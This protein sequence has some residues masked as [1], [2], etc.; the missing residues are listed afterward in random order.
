[1]IVINEDKDKLPKD[2]ERDSLINIEN[3]TKANKHVFYDNET[4]NN[5]RKIGN[6]Y[7]F[8]FSNGNPTIVIGPH[9]ILL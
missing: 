7:L 2:H 9:C 8:A 1:M 4:P 3:K 6:T 5:P